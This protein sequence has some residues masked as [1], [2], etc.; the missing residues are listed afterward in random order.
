V[1]QNEV[2]KRN[3]RRSSNYHRCENLTIIY[4]TPL[5]VAA[6]FA[7]EQNSS[8]LTQSSLLV[9]EPLRQAVDVQVVHSLIFLLAW[10]RLS[11]APRR[12]LM[13]CMTSVF[14]VLSFVVITVISPC[15][16]PFPFFRSKSIMRKLWYCCPVGRVPSRGGILLPIIHSSAKACLFSAIGKHP[17]E[18]AS[19]KR[20]GEAA[21][22]LRTLKNKRGH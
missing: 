15:S 3:N 2:L 8:V 1:H 12:V 20:N 6:C 16:F 14:V 19:Y 21:K 22:A 18:S 13:R 10:F 5:M 7:C 9:V 17:R 11:G 4:L